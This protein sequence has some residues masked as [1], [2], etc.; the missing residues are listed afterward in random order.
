ML[1]TRIIPP[2]AYRLTQRVWSNTSS[3]HHQPRHLSPP[4]HRNT[5]LHAY[6]A[7]Q[8]RIHVDSC[9][10]VE[11]PLCFHGKRVS[12]WWDFDNLAPS[13]GGAGAAVIMARRITVRVKHGQPSSTTHRTARRTATWRHLG[14]LACVRQRD[15]HVQARTQHAP[16]D[17]LWR[18]NGSSRQQ[19]VRHDERVDATTSLV[20]REAADMAIMSDVYWWAQQAGSEGVVV[21]VSSDH[22]FA[23]LLTLARSQGCTTVAVG[24]FDR[25]KAPLARA[26]RQVCDDT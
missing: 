10:H 2:T 14:T 1:F 20:H 25:R 7:L 26:T 9:T 17:G 22:G 5:C 16:V 21:L 15:D 12:V 6:N 18:H 23:Q 4:F 19:K 11:L 24:L 8:T 3:Q 13:G